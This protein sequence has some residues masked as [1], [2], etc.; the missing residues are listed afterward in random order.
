MFP[1]SFLVLREFNNLISIPGGDPDNHFNIGPSTGVIKVARSLDYEF[2]TKYV[3]LVKATD[4]GTPPLSNTMTV[5]INLQDVNDNKPTCAETSVVVS[6]L[7]NIPTNTQVC[8]YNEKKPM[9]L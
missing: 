1:A 2:K 9:V 4:G 5:T 8:D 3:M 6:I 7:E